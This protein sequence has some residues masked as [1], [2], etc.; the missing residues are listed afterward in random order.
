MAE[1]LEGGCFCG[2]VRY[3]TVQDFC[4]AHAQPVL[5]RAELRGIPGANNLH[6]SALGGASVRHTCRVN[7]RL[8]V[9]SQ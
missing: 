8:V 1:I 7:E 9:P 6:V 3:R 5:K 2:T 4:H